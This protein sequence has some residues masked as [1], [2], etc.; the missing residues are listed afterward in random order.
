MRR[1]C[2]PSVRIF[3]E[4]VLPD[5][6]SLDFSKHFR[7]TKQT[8]TR[9]PQD[10]ENDLFV[11]QTPSVNKKFLTTETEC[12]I[13]GIAGTI[14]GSHIIL[15][16]ESLMEIKITLTEKVYPSFQLQNIVDNM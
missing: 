5:F 4:D 12:K 8:F 15:L 16:Q 9:L 11:G 6:S 13:P 1:D 3:Y 14:D 2:V 10:I 7:L